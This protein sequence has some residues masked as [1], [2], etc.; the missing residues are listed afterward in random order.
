MPNSGCKTPI[1]S[2]FDA[3]SFFSSDWDDEEEEDV[4]HGDVDAMVREFES[5]QRVKFSAREWLELYR[6]YASQFPTQ[7][8]QYRADT[9]IKII[10]ETAIQQYPYM[11]IFSLHMVEWLVRDQKYTKARSCISHALQY[12]PFEP[13][14]GFMQALVFGLQGHKK[15]A[16]DELLKVLQNA[17]EEEAMLEDFLE[18]SLYHGQFDLAMPILEKALDAGSEVSVILEKYIEKA[19]EG[20]LIES[21]LPMIQ[22]IIDQ[23]PY[24]AEAW[25]VLG[26]GHMAKGDHEQALKALDFAIT[27]N[28]NFADAWITYLE[29]I[30]EL[31]QYEEFIKLYNELQ[32]KFPKKTFAEIE[33]LLAWS[34]YEQGDV[35][36]CRMLYK[37]IIKQ[38]PQDAECWYSM[39]LTWHYE[40]NYS[41][42]IPYLER[43]YNLDHFESDYGM[44]LASAYFGAHM[45]EKW[46]A[47]YESLRVEHTSNPEVWLNYSTSLYE[48]GE[49]GRALEIVET[50]L[51]NIPN[52]CGLLYRLAALCYLSGQASAALFVLEKALELN[53]NEHIQLFTFAPELRH[54]T[55]ILSC[56]S[57]FT[58]AR[59]GL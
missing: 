41:A 29:C 27:I 58:Q 56:I 57:K 2:N 18:I 6:F 31:G 26:S 13:A 9:Y 45:Q 47:L 59:T 50:G 38:Q 24:S 14:L 44:V 25:Y 15:K 52:H 43:A 16:M 34:Y 32:L 5:K 7:T 54:A 40:E 8:G 20:G 49:T 51:Q 11:P 1:K 23:D 19:E 30:Y 55:Q 28:D 4:F 21:L 37:E 42:A 22:R 48:V 35:K 17:G 53:A 46:E 12:A 36:T 10:L 39:G 33:G 3:M